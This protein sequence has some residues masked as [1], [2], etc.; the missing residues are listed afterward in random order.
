MILGV[1]TAIRALR[2]VEGMDKLGPAYLMAKEKAVEKK[3][4]LRIGLM[5]VF[6]EV[7]VGCIICFSAGAGNI[8]LHYY[9]KSLPPGRV[10]FGE[11]CD[12]TYLSG[13]A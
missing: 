3:N 2:S 11:N 4:T 1:K 8:D 7:V 12:R 13:A 10:G 9:A 5:L 6:M